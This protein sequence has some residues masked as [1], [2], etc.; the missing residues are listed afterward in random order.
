MRQAA[1]HSLSNS[2]SRGAPVAMR[3]EILPII[4][5]IFDSVQDFDNG[6]Q[7]GFHKQDAGMS[8][9]GKSRLLIW[10]AVCLLAYA[11]LG[12]YLALPGY[13]RFLERGGSI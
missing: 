10:G 4:R 8:A 6:P 9:H 2:G 3:H 7:I 11:L 1:Q 12:N 5:K 13:V